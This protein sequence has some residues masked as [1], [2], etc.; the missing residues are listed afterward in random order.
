MSTD[1]PTQVNA[2]WFDGQTARRTEVV[3]RV[4]SRTVQVRRAGADADADDGNT[5]DSTGDTTIAH[6]PRDSV[7]VS[8]RIGDAPYRLTFPDGG[9]AVTSDHGAV[10]SAFGLSPSRHWLSR[11]ERAR[12]VVV[13]VLVGLAAAVFFAY[14]T[15][16][17][18]AA[19]AVAQRIPR[20]TEQTLGAVALQGL[21]RW[22][23]KTSRLEANELSA[24]HELFAELVETAKLTD[25]V[26]LQFRD[27]APNALALPGGTVIVTDGLVRLFKADER[28]LAGVIAHELG[29]VQHRHSLR[30][31]L[32]GSAS[33]LM[34]GA[35]LGDVSGVSTLVTAAPLLLSTLHYT[36]EAEMEADQYAFDLLKKSG[37]SANDFAD[38]MRRFEAMELCMALRDKQRDAK[39]N[40]AWHLG[41]ASDDEPKASDGDENLATGRPSCLI[42]PDSAIKGHESELTELRKEDQE[43]GYMHTHPVTQERIRAAEA[44]AAK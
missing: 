8:E 44:A 25:A 7:Q 35:L 14:Q 34:V 11:M 6:I 31:L 43:T 15:L 33:S 3:L 16:I 24:V 30:H 22:M 2:M 17:P 5:D 10:E 28:L 12:W 41:V 1:I 37:R 38:A 26:E 20:E 13:A 32:A 29:H 21:D 19:N 18:L 4:T 23:L 42:D 40:S 27:A 9:L 36:R 39:N